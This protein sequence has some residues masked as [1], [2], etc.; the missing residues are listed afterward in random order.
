VAPYGCPSTGAYTD[1][2]LYHPPYHEAQTP[3]GRLHL[4]WQPGDWALIEAALT[5]PYPDRDV[6]VP[7]YKLLKAGTASPQRLA[8]DLGEMPGPWNQLRLEAGLAVFREVGLVDEDGR[9]KGAGGA[10]FDLEASPRYRRGLTGRAALA[11]QRAFE[12]S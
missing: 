8:A 5:W 3:G 11:R 2:V 10:K 6:L 4:L 7:L 12:M 1:T 9:L